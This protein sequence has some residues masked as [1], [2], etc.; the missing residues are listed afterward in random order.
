MDNIA[1]VV[2]AVCL[3]GLILFVVYDRHHN[4]G[5]LIAIRAK[6]GELKMKFSNLKNR[7]K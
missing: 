4:Y 1:I 2:S 7:K 6:I 5:Y 3:L